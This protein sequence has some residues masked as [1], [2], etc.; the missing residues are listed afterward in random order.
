M[1]RF[2]QIFEDPDYEDSYK[3]DYTDWATDSEQ[4]QKDN[5]SESSAKDKDL[6]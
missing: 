4:W 5:E 2:A 1:S 3:D 6:S